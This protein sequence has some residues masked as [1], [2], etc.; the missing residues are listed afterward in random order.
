MMIRWDYIMYSPDFHDKAVEILLK[1]VE[2]L[3]MT[4]RDLVM[5]G[6]YFHDNGSRF[7]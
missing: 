5:K 4:G 1:T 7:S 3:I 6:R 2:I